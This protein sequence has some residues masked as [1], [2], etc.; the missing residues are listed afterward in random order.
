MCTSGT[1]IE[2]VYLDY[3]LILDKTNFQKTCWVVKPKYQ[4]EEISSIYVK[5]K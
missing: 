4:N 2:T 1:P 3:E 5:V